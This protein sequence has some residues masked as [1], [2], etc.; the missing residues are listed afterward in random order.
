M[1]DFEQRM[2]QRKTHPAEMLKGLLSDQ[3]FGINE[4]VEKKYGIK[5]LL[6]RDGTI[7]QNGYSELYAAEEMQADANLVREREIEFQAYYRN[8][9]GVQNEDERIAKWREA[10]SREKSGQTEMAVTALLSK[11]LGEDFLVV[12]TAP[13]DD[14]KNGLDPL[15]VN[16]S[17]G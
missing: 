11:M 3:S 13:Y 12:R 17:K 15:I 1:N 16:R 7:N 8:Q 4:A 14:Y 5:S 10:R 6:E 9:P 2:M